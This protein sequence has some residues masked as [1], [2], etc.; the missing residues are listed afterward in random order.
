MAIN[1]QELKVQPTVLTVTPA[2]TDTIRNLLEQRSIPNHVLR[3]FV[4]G[5]GCSGMQYGMA[6]E[7]APQEFDQV[8][9]QGFHLVRLVV[10]GD[11][12]AHLRKPLIQKLLT[13]MKL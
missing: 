2:A 4:A 13:A 1:P 5:G 10:H 9:E 3:V 12:A 11:V 7:E 8:I 6:F